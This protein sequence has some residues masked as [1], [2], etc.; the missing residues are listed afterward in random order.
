MDIHDV[1]AIPSAAAVE[2][3]SDYYLEDIVQMLNFMPMP[4]ARKKKRKNNSGTADDND[5]EEVI[6]LSPRHRIAASGRAPDNHPD[7]YMSS[8]S[9]RSSSGA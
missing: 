6:F 4:D 8:E 1:T 3:F 5:D 2:L 7:T 9:E